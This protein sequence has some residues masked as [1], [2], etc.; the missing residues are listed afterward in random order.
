MLGEPQ[1]PR[2]VGKEGAVTLG[3]VELASVELGQVANQIDRGL[4]LWPREENDAMALLMS[5]APA[6]YELA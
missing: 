4:S 5:N 2:A 1:R 3:K 6:E